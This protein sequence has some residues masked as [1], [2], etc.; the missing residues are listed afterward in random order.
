MSIKKIFLSV[1]VALALV[2]C[3]PPDN[4]RAIETVK[5]FGFSD[6]VVTRSGLNNNTRYN[7]CDK[8]DGEYYDVTAT[9]IA[10]ARVNL[11]VCC[12]HYSNKGCTLRTR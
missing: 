8:H 3:E 4:N 6:P 9:N 7:G 5:T 11:I 1:A 2:S 10:G 12:G